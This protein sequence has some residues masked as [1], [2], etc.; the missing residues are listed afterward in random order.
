MTRTIHAPKDSTRRETRHRLPGITLM[1]RRR[2]KGREM[3]LRIRKERK[4]KGRE[5]LGNG[6]LGESTAGERALR[7]VGNGM[8]L[9]LAQ[10]G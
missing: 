1:V 10:K 3:N 9:V 8:T 6:P 5:E 7:V 2:A 4:G